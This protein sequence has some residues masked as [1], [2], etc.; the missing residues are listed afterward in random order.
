MSQTSAGKL[1]EEVQMRWNGEVRGKKETLQV[2]TK[3]YA[4]KPSVTFGTHNTYATLFIDWHIVYSLHLYLVLSLLD[5]DCS[6]WFNQ[7]Q[8]FV[9][10]SFD[11]ASLYIT[12]KT[13]KT[14]KKTK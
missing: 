14:I 7:M 6:F 9:M 3:K 5:N 11:N 13:L 1:Y 12:P 2:K 10:L 8:F 4:R